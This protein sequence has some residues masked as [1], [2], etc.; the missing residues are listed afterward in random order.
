[1]V[2]D[3]HLRLSVEVYYQ[4]KIVFW[5]IALIYINITISDIS[6]TISSERE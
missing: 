5:G 4:V 3:F 2:S 6:N 1:M